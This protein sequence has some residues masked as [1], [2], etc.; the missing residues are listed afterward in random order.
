LILC[1][2]GGRLIERSSTP[3]SYLLPFFL[4]K[5][6]SNMV[7]ITAGYGLSKIR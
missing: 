1:V 3:L 5:V 6:N 4:E 2:K 7:V